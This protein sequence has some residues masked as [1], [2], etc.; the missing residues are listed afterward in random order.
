MSLEDFD[1]DPSGFGSEFFRKCENFLLEIGGL[2]LSPDP[3]F[4]RPLTPAEEEALFS[5]LGE[6]HIPSDVAYPAYAAS[7]QD[8]GNNQGGVEEE[9]G[10]AGNDDRHDAAYTPMPSMSAAHDPA[11]ATSTANSPTPAPTTDTSGGCPYP[12]CNNKDT[13]ARHLATHTLVCWIHGCSD[14][15]PTFNSPQGIGKHLM[16]VHNH[17]DSTRCHWPNCRN[18][19]PQRKCHLS[20]H[21][22]I[23]NYYLALERQASQ[24]AAAV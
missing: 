20:L 18:A 3:A 16:T 22:R 5:Q 11:P 2:G 21:L 17:N 13:K 19:N 14:G 24:T 15:N 6:S 9:G 10:V 7:G 8:A 4:Y 23:H 1:R 12:G